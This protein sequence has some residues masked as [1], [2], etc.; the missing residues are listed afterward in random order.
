MSLFRHKYNKKQT[1]SQF[2][3]CLILTEVIMSTSHP[4]MFVSL[5]RLDNETKH[6]SFHF[7]DLF[8]VLIVE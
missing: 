5:K 3:T 4:L 6:I 8:F 1:D 2:F 7:S